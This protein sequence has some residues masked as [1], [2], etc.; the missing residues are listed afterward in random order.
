MGNGASQR[1]QGVSAMRKAESPR[2][3]GVMGAGVVAVLLLFA[4]ACGDDDSGSSTDTPV[5]TTTTTTS[6]TAAPAATTTSTTAAPVATTTSTTEAPTTTTAAPKEMLDPIRQTAEIRPQD[7]GS[8][9]VYTE[10]V[11]E[12]TPEQVWEVLTDFDT[13]PQWSSTFQGLT[14]DLSDGGQATA[15]FTTPDGTFPFPHV[16]SWDEGLSFSWSDPILFAPGITDDHR[17]VV[18]STDGEATLFVQTDQLTGDN[19]ALPAAELAETL[20]VLYVVFNEEFKAE[21]ESRY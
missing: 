13:M 1:T 6:T 21:V 19:D 8:L 18:D 5:T 11:I 10:I 15:T 4:G 17:Y 12:A 2:F 3:A 20:R 14:G 7:D 16:I 9:L